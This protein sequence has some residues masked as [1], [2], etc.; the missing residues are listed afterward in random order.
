MESSNLC[1]IRNLY[2]AIAEMEMQLERT[3]GLNINEA[4]LLCLINERKEL[5]SGEI[6]DELRLSRSN[7][8]KVIVAME[9]GGFVRRHSDKEDSRRQCFR[10]T[11]EGEKMLAGIHC[12]D[13]C[14]PEIIKNA[15]KEQ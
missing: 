2:R 11:R 13:V 3:F 8:S 14:I 10:L 4:M 12:C 7:T 1:K 5:L 9:K 6:A 15:I